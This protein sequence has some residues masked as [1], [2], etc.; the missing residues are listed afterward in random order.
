[1]NPHFAATM[2]YQ[3]F[4]AAAGAK[5]YARNPVGRGRGR[6]QTRVPPRSGEHPLV[7]LHA[8]RIDNFAFGGAAASGIVQAHEGG[9]SC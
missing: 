7:A 6:A 4:A 5:L 3:H 9:A 8:Y 2:H 1:M